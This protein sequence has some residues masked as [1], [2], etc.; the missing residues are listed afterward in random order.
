MT[1]GGAQRNQTRRR[2]RKWRVV[3][4]IRIKYTTFSLIQYSKHMTT[5]NALISQ[6]ERQLTIIAIRIDNK[7]PRRTQWFSPPAE[8]KTL[9]WT[10]KRTLASYGTTLMRSSNTS[11]VMRDLKSRDAPTSSFIDNLFGKCYWIKWNWQR[12][13]DAYFIFALLITKR[14][15][16]IRVTV[17]WK[18]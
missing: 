16:K 12:S 1:D 8:I 3:V 9:G 7:I 4:I 13:I 14:A 6:C 5:D 11:S 17:K 2:N 10:I 15:I 18:I